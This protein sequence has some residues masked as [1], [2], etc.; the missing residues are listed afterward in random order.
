MMPLD[1]VEVATTVGG[2]ASAIAGYL[3]GVAAL[4]FFGIVCAC[5]G[6][7]VLL[8]RILGDLR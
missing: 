1:L 8:S 2:I 7:G 3:L 6:L 4:E 5:I